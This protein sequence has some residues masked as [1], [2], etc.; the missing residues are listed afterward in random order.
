MCFQVVNDSG[1]VRPQV[2]FPL[3]VTPSGAELDLPGKNP[4]KPEKCPIGTF[5]SDEEFDPC[6]KCPQGTFSDQEGSD[7]C[8]GCGADEFTGKEEG[9]TSCTQCPCMW[10]FCGECVK[11]ILHVYNAVPLVLWMI[12]NA[13]SL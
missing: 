9:Q 8:R 12:W 2:V 3:S 1:S 7:H 5:T 4:F 11:C 13:L 6:P 10:K